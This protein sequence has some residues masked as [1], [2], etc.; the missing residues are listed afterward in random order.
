MRGLVLFCACTSMLFGFDV[1]GIA[2]DSKVDYAKQIKPILARHCAEC[3]NSKKQQSGLRLDAGRLLVRGGDHGPSIVAGDSE[4]SLMYQVLI[5]KSDVSAMP[6]DRKPLS[7]AEISLIKAWIDQGV[8]YPQDEEIAGGVTSDHWAFQPVNRPDT[9]QV[10]NAGWVRNPIDAFILAR[11]EKEGLSPSS[12][13][14]QQTLIRRLYLDLLGI[15][16]S[17]KEIELYVADIR[18]DAY[19]QL[20]NRILASPRYGERWGRHWLDI[21]RYADSNGFTID[22]P[23]Q[24]WKYRDWVVDALNRDLPFDQFTI[25][26]TAGD[27]LPNPTIDQIVATGFHRNTLINQ[28]GGT[29]DEQFRVESVVDRVNTTGSVFLG[30]TIGCAQCHEHKFDPLT[31]RDFYR[32]YAFFN[33]TQDNNDANGSGP[34]ISVPAKAQL[35]LKKQLELEIAATEKPLKELDAELLKGLPAWEKKLA[36]QSGGS[37][38]VLDPVKWTTDKGAKLTKLSNK[39]LL[40]DFSV[41]ANDTYTIILETPMPNITAVRLEALTHPSLPMNGPGRAGNGNFVLSELELLA[42]PLSGGQDVKA[43]LVAIAKA[44]A[45]YSQDG[46]PIASA[47]DGKQDTGWA[48]TVKG[49]KTNVDR[50]AILVP[51]KTIHGESGSRLTVKLHHNHSVANYLMGCVRISVSGEAPETLTVPASIQKLA[52]TAADKRSKQQQQQL[53][54]AFKQTDPRRTPLATKL[55]GLKKRLDDLNRQIPT[56]MVLRAM[57]KPRTSFIQIRGDFLRRGAVVQPGV[58][59]VLSPLPPDIKSP[60]RLDFARWLVDPANPLTARVTVNRFWQRFFGIGIVETENDFGTQ[61]IAP[62]HPELLDWLASEFVRLQWGTKSMHRLIVTSAAYRQSSHMSPELLQRDPR[63]KLLARQSRLRLEAEAIR[64]TCL[65]V[66]GLLSDKMG[67]PGVY[68]PQPEGIYILTQQKKAWPEDKGEDRYR[69]GMYTY[70][71]RTAPYPLL[72]TFDAP[73]A[74]TTCTRRSRSNTPLQALTLAN[75]RAFFEI[76]QGLVVRTLGS[77]EA[78]DEGR[79]RFAF[80]TCLSR[81]PSEFEMKRL[82]E[83]LERQR[84]VFQEFPKQAKSVAPSRGIAYSKDIT[85]SDGAAWTAVARVLINL[86]EFITRN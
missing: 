72:P 63:N 70:I 49:G 2:A 27:M 61:G 18:P 58:P 76:A 7:K 68:P 48:V 66:S 16:P 86:D 59:E 57:E 75:D 34:K 5:G 69:R 23:R 26:Q 3:H 67:G 60:N 54:E 28:E 37:W 20:V 6:L 44:V 62:E 9:P 77:E 64:D 40:V 46:Y 80:R 50:E 82:T 25:E 4:K 39:S 78:Y 29:S 42:E 35:A 47:I 43:Q 52:T 79:M 55:D 83:F 41:P 14:E 71:W 74:N 30:L 13:A 32:M 21:A 85:V 56:T 73:D 38:T 81:D 51:K 15:T 19:D 31:Q 53:E 45:D 11:L 36:S 10:K 24:I 84:K 1:P 22:G 65:S 12:E 8:K 17:I 33:N